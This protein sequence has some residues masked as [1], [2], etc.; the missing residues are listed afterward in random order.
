[1]MAH[2]DDDQLDEYR[3]LI[4]VGRLGTPLDVARAVDF[5]MAADSDYINGVTLD[6]NGGWFMA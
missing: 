1:M 3:S 6:V 5:L 2:L 4:P